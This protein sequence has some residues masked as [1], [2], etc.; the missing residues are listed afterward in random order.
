MAIEITLQNGH[1]ETLQ[2]EIRGVDTESD[3]KTLFECECYLDG[4]WIESY[5]DKENEDAQRIIEVQWVDGA[6][7]TSFHGYVLD[8][9]NSQG[10]E[11]VFSIA[12]GECQDYKIWEAMQDYFHGYQEA[13]NILI[14]S[15]G[16]NFL[17]GNGF[18]FQTLFELVVREIVRAY[19]R[20]HN[21]ADI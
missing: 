10:I 3:L 14:K 16:L 21:I 19:L 5:V 9:M 12:C 4:S 7:E 13:V 20:E 17:F 18:C 1:T 15:D 11:T 2:G 6:P 8:Y